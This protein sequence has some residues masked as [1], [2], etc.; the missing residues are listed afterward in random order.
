MAGFGCCFARGSGEFWGASDGEILETAWRLRCSL[1]AF[2]HI[3]N[4]TPRRALRAWCMA[5]AVRRE[6][7]TLFC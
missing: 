4:P 5:P 2:G 6:P 3:G 7:T 1:V